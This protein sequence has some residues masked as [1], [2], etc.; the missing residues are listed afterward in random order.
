MSTVVSVIPVRPA[1]SQIIIGDSKASP[2][3]FKGRKLSLN[4]YKIDKTVSR[5]RRG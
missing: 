4:D 5:L 1:A 3:F 2:S